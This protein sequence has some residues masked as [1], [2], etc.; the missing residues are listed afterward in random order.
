M[1]NN[2]SLCSL[3]FLTWYLQYMLPS[4][5]NNS[6]V[7]CSCD[8]DPC[9][10]SSSRSSHSHSRAVCCRSSHIVWV[11]FDCVSVEGRF[12]SHLLFPFSFSSSFSPSLPLPLPL[13][14]SLSS[15]LPDSRWV[16]APSAAGGDALPCPHP[17]GALNLP[18]RRGDLE[19]R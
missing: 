11:E 8:G 16:F 14:L 12:E 3:L 18:A 6:K 10:R 4:I 5:P 19:M 7:L 1:N 13:P 15:A 17:C 2:S 9:S